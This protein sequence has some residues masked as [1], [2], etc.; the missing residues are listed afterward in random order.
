MNFKFISLSLFSLTAVS[1]LF[2]PSFTPSALALGC[3]AI[4]VAVQVDVSG[5]RNPGKQTNNVN[6]EFGEDCKP[7]TNVTNRSTQIN[8]GPNSAI[9]NRNSNAVVG[10]GATSTTPGKGD[11]GVQVHVPVQVY[12]PGQDPEFLKKVGAP[13]R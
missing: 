7:G 6:Q 5:N 4:D 3:S 8:I 12:N 1:P 13:Q 2:V 9:Q 11:V 10:E